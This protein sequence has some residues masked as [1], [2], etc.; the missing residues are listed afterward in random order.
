VFDLISRE[1]I[2]FSIGEA[3]PEEIDEINIRQATFLAMRRAIDGVEG[4]DAALVDGV[5]IPDFDLHHEA[6]VKGDRFVRSIAAASILAK[7][8]RD[9]LL[10]EYADLYPVYGFDAHK[11]YGTAVHLSALREHGPCE[12]HRMTF[13]RV[14]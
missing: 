10:V 8:T 3:S 4:V 14:K 1:A 6:V 9:R 7:V 12:V 13:A 11:G 5:P 2:A